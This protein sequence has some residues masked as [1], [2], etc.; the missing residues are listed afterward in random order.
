MNDSLV[1]RAFTF[2]FREL[3]F[4]VL[5][6]PLWWYSKGLV[7]VGRFI[8]REIADWGARLSLRI[9]ARN[10]FKPMYGDYTR[11]GRAISFFMRFFVF[12]TKSIVFIGWSV[13][14][15]CIGLIWLL[16]PIAVIYFIYLNLTGTS[17][18]G[19]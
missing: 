14:L 1:I 11:S 19:T 13:V 17:L 10:M 4:D 7:N 3:I 12:I 15:L 6:F 18:I 2:I 9:L 16:L 5:R 8:G